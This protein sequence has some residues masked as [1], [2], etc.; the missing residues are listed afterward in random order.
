MLTEKFRNNA[1]TSDAEANPTRAGTAEA[2]SQYESVETS[3]TAKSGPLKKK[4]RLL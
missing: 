4:A 2:S 3:A 1:A